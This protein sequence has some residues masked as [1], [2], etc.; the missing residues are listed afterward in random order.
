MWKPVCAPETCTHR[1]RKKPTAKLPDTGDVPFCADTKFTRNLLRE[2]IRDNH[3]FVTGNTVIDALLAVRDRIMQ[4]KALLAQLDAQ[5][6]FIDSSK[7]DSGH[8]A[9]S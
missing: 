5:Y 3:I 4:D 6:P 8:R 9:P 2:G 1:G 7:N